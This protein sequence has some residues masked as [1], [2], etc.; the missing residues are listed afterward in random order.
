[1]AG[2]FCFGVAQQ[3]PNISTAIE[4]D[5]NKRTVFVKHNV[6]RIDVV[7]NKSKQVQMSDGSQNPF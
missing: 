6:C 1:M 4:I 3:L 2:S 5:E 7:M